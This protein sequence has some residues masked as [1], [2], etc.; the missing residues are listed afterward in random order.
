MTPAPPVLALTSESEPGIRPLVVT[1]EPLL[2]D[3]LLRLA[4]AAGATVDAVADADLA[5]RYWNSAPLVLV[6][7]DRVPSCVAVGLPR[8]PGV[9]LVSSDLDDGGVWEAAVRL[10]AEHVAFLP[11]AEEWMVDVLVDATEADQ[12]RGTVV[13]VVGG[14]GGA[15]ATSLSIALTLA[16]LRRGF[17]TVLVDADPLGGGIDLALG[18]EDQPGMRWPDLASAHG[19]LPRRMLSEAL[20]SLGELPVLSWDRISPTVIAPSAMTSILTS[21]RRGNDLLVVDLPR[22]PDQ[23]TAVAMQLAK[24][25]L[26]VVPAEVRAIAAAG[27]VCDTAN[28]YC[29]D[30]RVVVRLPGP[31]GLQAD[32]VSDALALPVAGILRHEQGLA[33]GL[34]RGEP[35]GSRRRSSL[36]RV[37]GQIL[38]DLGLPR[39]DVAA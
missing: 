25:I 32:T 34:E 2:L 35:P 30:V 29:A 9:V 38:N 36:A 24:I 7:A 8:R 19:R 5:R 4:A 23:T 27:R 37:S 26:V 10:G 16:S 39:S 1:D 21:A 22:F 18:I 33:S 15:G 6:G 20:P 3:D 13:G 31:A 11:D 14:R 12:R 17:S 28:R